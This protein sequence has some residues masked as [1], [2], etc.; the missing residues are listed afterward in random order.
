MTDTAVLPAVADAVTAALAPTIRRK[1]AGTDNTADESC[2]VLAALDL[3]PP[4]TVAGAKLAGLFRSEAD[5]WADEDADGLRQEIE[6]RSDELL[7]TVEVLRLADRLD[8]NGN[9]TG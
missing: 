6:D 4:T 3:F 7:A 8:G 1:L 5:Q 2:L 9:F